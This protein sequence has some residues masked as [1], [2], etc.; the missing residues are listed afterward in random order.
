LSGSTLHPIA[1][2]TGCSFFFAGPIFT[3]TK[4]LKVG[5]ER[6][7]ADSVL[8]KPHRLDLR[9]A[10]LAATGMASNS[11]CLAPDLHH[12]HASTNARIAKLSMAARTLAR[13]GL[14]R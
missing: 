12:A 11:G 14:A 10:R 5:I 7:H 9:G 6:G 13:S 2:A 8:I 4:I 3:D 1:C